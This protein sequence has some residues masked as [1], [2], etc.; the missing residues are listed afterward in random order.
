MSSG[1]RLHSRHDL[2]LF[3]SAAI[4]AVDQ[5]GVDEGLDSSLGHDGAT[6]QLEQF[7]VVQESQL[8]TPWEHSLLTEIPGQHIYGLDYGVFNSYLA[9]LP[10]SSRTSAT[11]YSRTL[12]M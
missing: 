6:G 3:L 7:L 12:A 4:A 1:W 5:D 2:W 10:A 11:R 9:Q 8:D